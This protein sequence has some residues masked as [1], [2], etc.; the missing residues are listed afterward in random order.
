MD[1]EEVPPPLKTRGYRETARKIAIAV[2][3]FGLLLAPFLVNIGD[4]AE[5]VKWAAPLSKLNRPLPSLQALLL[6]Q[7]WTLFSELSPFNFKLNYLV[8]LTNGQTVLLPDLNKENAGKW[9]PILFPN[10]PKFELNL[11]SDPTAQRL[12]LEYLVRING[13]DP[14]WITKRTVY[15]TYQ[16][17]LSREESR[18]AGS[19]YEPDV[20][21]VLSTY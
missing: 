2:L 17:V 6:C 13:L 18:R 9:E 5:H 20:N 14:D 7:Q 12:Y 8:E 3:W 19:H 16:N 10:E 1:H 11:Y 15:M 4:N 21:F